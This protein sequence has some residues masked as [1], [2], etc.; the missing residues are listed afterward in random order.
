MNTDPTP[1]L[2]RDAIA[3]RA[4]ELSDERGRPTDQ[5]V[6]IWL[7]AERQLMGETSAAAPVVSTKSTRTR[8]RA[9]AD[10][11][12]P[13]EVNERLDDFGEPPRRSATSVDLT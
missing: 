10:S 11:I 6:P 9:S 7:E 2:T 12:K 13:G 1:P 8:R 4:R 5:D 3:R